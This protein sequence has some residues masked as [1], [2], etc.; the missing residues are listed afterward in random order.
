[1]VNLKWRLL[2]QFLWLCGYIMVWLSWASAEFR[3]SKGSHPTLPYETWLEFFQAFNLY[4][5]L[6]LLTLSLSACFYIIF[7]SFFI[8]KKYLLLFVIFKI[9]IIVGYI[10]IIIYF[11]TTNSGQNIN[12]Y[13]LCLAPLFL[14]PIFVF[15][16]L[17]VTMC[18]EIVARC[19]KINFSTNNDEQVLNAIYNAMAFLPLLS[20]LNFILDYNIIHY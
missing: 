11:L 1:M 15:L 6:I 3:A 19:K 14:S 4:A 8:E 5:P 17:I 9:S 7:K 13:E 2:K 18:E 12:F 16:I 20:I 10:I